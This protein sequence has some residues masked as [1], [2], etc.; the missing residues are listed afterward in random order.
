MRIR[1]IFILVLTIFGVQVEAQSNPPKKLIDI[2]SCEELINS[3][4][5]GGLSTDAQAKEA[6]GYHIQ[7]DAP[8][9]M[10]KAVDYLLAHPHASVEHA[11]A[12]TNFLL[13]L[14]KRRFA[15]DYW[16]YVQFSGVDGSVGFTGGSGRALVISPTGGLYKGIIYATL[17]RYQGPFVWNG[18]YSKL[19]KVGDFKILAQ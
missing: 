11:I 16:N 5:N 1:T 3:A 9:L 14:I 10:R 6:I 4:A 19:I 7:D 17:S 13:Q 15:R 8:T 2:L 18:D 12:D